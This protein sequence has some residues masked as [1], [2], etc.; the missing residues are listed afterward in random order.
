MATPARE[1]GS[2]A[3]APASTRLPRDG[4][5][6]WSERRCAAGCRSSCSPGRSNRSVPLFPPKC[7]PP[8]LE[9]ASRHHSPRL[10]PRGGNRL[11]RL[12]RA[13][14][15]ARSR[16]RSGRPPTTSPSSD[17]HPRRPAPQRSRLRHFSARLASNG[18]SMVVG[19]LP[20]LNVRASRVNKPRWWRLQMSGDDLP[21]D[22]GAGHSGSRH[23]LLLNNVGSDAEVPIAQVHVL[24]PT[25]A[26]H[27]VT[28]ASGAIVGVRTPQASCSATAL[29]PLVVR[30][31]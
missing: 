30:D 18:S 2:N 11:R 5:S 12:C 23:L 8:H 20:S 6:A 9:V 10:S 16:R 4:G 26:C 28:R 31:R 21:R 13:A 24:L 27:F 14:S 25:R 29:P 15:V 17:Q 22:D 19:K 1:E 3:T 7:A